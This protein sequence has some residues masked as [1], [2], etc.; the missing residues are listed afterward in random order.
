M[1][2]SGTL[3]AVDVRSKF[4]RALE[5]GGKRVGRS[6]RLGSNVGFGVAGSMV[7]LAV[8][9][10]LYGEIGKG[11]TALGAAAAVAGF[12]ALFRFL[13]SLMVAERPTDERAGGSASGERL[14]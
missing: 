4:E 14:T 2:R 12:A 8:A 11:V 13:S 10:L 6:Y 5:N 3:S 9:S 7:G 1:K